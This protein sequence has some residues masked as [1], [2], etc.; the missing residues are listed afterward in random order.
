MKKHFYAVWENYYPNSASSNRMLAYMEAWSKLDVE[1][2]MVIM[3]PDRKYSRVDVSYSNIRI[4]YL[5]DRLPVHNY[6]IQNILL[7]YYIYSF[8][9]RLKTGDS[10][11]L[12]GQA[13]LMDKLLNSRKT[14]HV[15]QER[16]E[17]PLIV[18]PGH[19]P[20][21]VSIKTYLRDCTKLDGMFVISSP[22]QKFFEESGLKKGTVYVVNMIV[23]PRRFEGVRKSDK[24]KKYIAY[25]GNASNNKDGVD[26]LIKAFALI[27]PKYQDIYLYVIGKAPDSNEENNNAHLAEELGVGDKV[28]FTG[29]VKADDMP[30]L[31]TDADILALDRPDSLQAQNGFPTKLGEY[32]ITGNPVVVTSVGDIPLFLKDGVSAMIAEPSNPEQFAAKLEWLLNNRDDACKIGEQGKRVALKFFNSDTE[33]KKIVDVIIKA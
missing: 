19:W 4:I 15:Y 17:H 8:I 7:G 10:I 11:F 2:T 28:I 33:A 1:V 31:L 18:H 3:L 16:T 13:F 6:L 23:D 14:I 12:Y 5:W 25:C 26:Q 24:N 22:L 20:Y 29:M 9:K 32:L 30:Q 21:K 27:S